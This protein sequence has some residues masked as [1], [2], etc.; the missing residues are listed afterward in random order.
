M[1]LTDLNKKPLNLNKETGPIDKD[2]IPGLQIKLLEEYK[3]NFDTYEKTIGGK[4]NYN[5]AI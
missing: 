5:T 2:K 3:Y 4:V 1:H